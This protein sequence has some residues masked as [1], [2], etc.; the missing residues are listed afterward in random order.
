MRKTK[1]F[2][3]EGYDKNFEVKELKLKEIIGLIQDDVTGG[4]TSIESLKTVFESRLLPLCS[5][6]KVDELLEMT[7]SELEEFWNHFHEVN[8]S[9]FGLARKAGIQEVLE[10]LKQAIIADFT[11]LLVSSSKQDTPAS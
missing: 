5:N 2:K 1:T 8:S 10:E 11:R 3:I 7:P 9:F 6:V 4:D